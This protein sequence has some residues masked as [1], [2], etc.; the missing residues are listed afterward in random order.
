VLFEKGFL[1]RLLW[2]RWNDSLSVDLLKAAGA[3]PDG[4]LLLLAGRAH[5]ERDRFR[6]AADVYEKAATTPSLFRAAGAQALADKVHCA[7]MVRDKVPVAQR[8]E[9]QRTVLEDIRRLLRDHRAAVELWCR[10]TVGRPVGPRES[11]SRI[12]SLAS[13]AWQCADID[14]AR[15]ILDEW[16]RFD[17]E[18]LRLSFLRMEVEYTAGCYEEAI[19]LGDAILKRNP[20]QPW[21]RDEAQNV[22]VLARQKLLDAAKRYRVETPAGPAKPGKH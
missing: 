15:Q 9:F 21:L 19:K 2:A 18:N 22:Q 8:A 13:M 12:E 17:A 20:D 7:W 10:A 16:R 11:G 5:E 14:L 3:Y 1:G 6:E 4:F